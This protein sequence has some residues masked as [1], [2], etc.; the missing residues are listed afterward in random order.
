M[1]NATPKMKTPAQHRA[2]FAKVGELRRLGG[3]SAEDAE[4]VLRRHCEAVSGS[5]RTSALTE[6]GAR[7]VLQRL[8]AELA[9]YT[10]APA[11]PRPDETGN[12]IFLLTPAQRTMLEGLCAQAK[13]PLAG[14]CQRQL[15]RDLPRT[16]AEFDQ[17][18]H[19]LQDIVLRRVDAAATLA[20][21]V[22]LRGHPRLDPWKAGF[23]EDLHTQLTAKGAKAL[24]THKL[25]KLD[26]AERWVARR[27]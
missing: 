19:A 27:G 24:T 5:R 11:P 12:A 23:I 4:E 10:P 17:V 18:I 7:E 8:S 21:V 9:A 16:N 2:L 22:A 25:A 20:R 1:S 14:F 26:E 15:G 13:L 6:Q 3:L